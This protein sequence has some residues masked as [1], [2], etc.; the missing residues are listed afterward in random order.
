[1]HVFTDDL[2]LHVQVYMYILDLLY[3]MSN[4]HTD[5]SRHGRRGQQKST[6]CD[7]SSAIPNDFK[8]TEASSLRLQVAQMPRA[9]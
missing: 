7:G 6:I 5:C 2:Y 8:H 1:M 9:V 4:K 3:T